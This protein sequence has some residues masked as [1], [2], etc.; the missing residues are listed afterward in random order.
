[1]NIKQIHY[2]FMHMMA[3]Y[4][5]ENVKEIRKIYLKFTLRKPAPAC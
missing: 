4:F 5:L 2:K 1:M 3:I